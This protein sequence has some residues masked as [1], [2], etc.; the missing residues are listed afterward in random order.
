M[1]KANRETI[2]GV[3]FSEQEREDIRKLAQGIH[4]E[5]RPSAWVRRLV[6]DALA[7]RGQPNR[8]A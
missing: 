7:Q 5:L 3:R 6:L 4:R 2:L 1:A 8:A